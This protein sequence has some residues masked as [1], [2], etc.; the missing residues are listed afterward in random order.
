[1][2][3]EYSNFVTDAI[4]KLVDAYQMKEWNMS[5]EDFLKQAKKEM[6][7]EMNKQIKYYKDRDLFSD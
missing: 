6:K 3:D 1:M 2:I 5:F 4:E 7:K